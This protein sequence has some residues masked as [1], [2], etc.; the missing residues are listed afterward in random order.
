[1]STQTTLEH[2]TFEKTCSEFAVFIKSKQSELV[3]L[4]CRYETHDAAKD[5]IERSIEALEHV[6]EELEVIE[7]PLSDLKIATFFPLNL[8]LYS[9]TLFAIIPSI[10]AKSVF[11]RPP[12]VV[13]E[14]LNEICKLLEIKKYFPEISLKV[15]P[16]HIFVDLYASESDVIIFTGKY[17]NALAIQKLCPYSLLLYNGSGVNP[18]I[19]FENADIDLAAK[20]A[21]EMRCFNS[22]QDCA[23]PDAFFVHESLQS[24]FIDKLRFY[25]KDIVVGDT[26]D[27][28]T[29]IGP[30]MK[31]S[32]IDELLKWIEKQPSSIVYG[33]KVDRENHFVY[34]TIATTNVRDYTDLEFHEFFAPFFYVLTYSS[35]E[36]LNKI[37]HS[38]GFTERAMYASVFGDNE[39]V[40]SQLTFV[41]I[42]KNKIVNDVERGNEEYGGYG[43]KANFLLYGDQKVVQPVLV[44]RDIHLMLAA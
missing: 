4:L 28:K 31:Q 1:M 5:E 33:G 37:L 7:N 11:V 36:D 26:T 25:L 3:D 18:F 10:Y 35:E 41:K 9:L 27:E 14:I 34:P 13:G 20:K 38:P 23:G 17:E 8:P 2:S 15:T 12:E 21:V 42:L 29:D 30:T 6:K 24:E 22:G 44:G 16:R 43:P 40:E 39:A 19:I 32:Y